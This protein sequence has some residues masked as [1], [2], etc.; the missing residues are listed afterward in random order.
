V[1]DWP[2]PPIALPRISGRF[3]ASFRSRHITTSPAATITNAPAS[4]NPSII[5]PNTK[6]PKVIAQGSEK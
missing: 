2:G 4:A 5:V 1:G 3:T 6:N